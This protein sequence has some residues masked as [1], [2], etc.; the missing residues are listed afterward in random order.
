MRIQFEVAK[1]AI[2]IPHRCVVELQGQYSVFA[3]GK[4]NTVVS[5]PVVLGYQMGDL[6]LIEE[7]L[8]PDDMIVIDAIQ[9]VGTGVVIEPDVTT[10]ESKTNN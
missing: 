9:K 6:V 4:D 8:G 10:F 5:K 2:V 7:G 1:Q 3:V